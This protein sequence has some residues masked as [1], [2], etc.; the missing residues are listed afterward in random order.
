M[1]QRLDKICP[2]AVF[3]IIGYLTYSAL[4]QA[5]PRTAEA[6]PPPQIT[7]RMLSPET[8][9][10]VARAS[11]TD[12]DP[13]EVDWASYRGAGPRRASSQPASAPASQPATRPAKPVAERGP[14]LPAGRLVGVFVGEALRLAVIGERVYK[15]GSLVGG[16]DPESCWR[17]ETIEKDRVVLGFGKL[18]RVLTMPRGAPRAGLGGPEGKEPRP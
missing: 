18:R 15:E 9:T 12:R 14:P 4:R 7:K 13:F 17:V 5:G 16:A 1:L 8:I 3:L 2:Y 11:P 10:P 6:K